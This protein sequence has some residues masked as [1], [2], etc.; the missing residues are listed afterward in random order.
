[1]GSKLHSMEFHLLAKHDHP[2]SLLFGMGYIKTQ[3]NECQLSSF[4]RFVFSLNEWWTDFYSFIVHRPRIQ[5]AFLGKQRR[6]QS[7]KAKWNNTLNNSCLWNKNERCFFWQACEKY[8]LKSLLWRLG[9]F[10]TQRNQRFF[11]LAFAKRWHVQE[12]MQF[13]GNTCCRYIKGDI[14]IYFTVC[15]IQAVMS[16]HVPSVSPESK[17]STARSPN[18][19]ILHETISCTHTLSI[20]SRNSNPHL[21]TIFLAIPLLKKDCIHQPLVLPTPLN[22]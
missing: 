7:T 10:Q 13:S 4:Q 2:I 8:F 17:V 18:Q 16:T 22:K 6:M 3:L 9:Y 20:G 19:A 15:Y 12:G 5:P 11:F 14:G 1:M 21:R